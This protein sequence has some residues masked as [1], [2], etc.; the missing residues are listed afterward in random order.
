MEA[1]FWDH[2]RQG[3]WFL[4]PGTWTLCGDSGLASYLCLD[5]LPDVAGSKVLG[6][7]AFPLSASL[8]QRAMPPA[9]GRGL[10]G[11]PRSIWKG[12]RRNSLPSAIPESTTRHVTQ[13]LPLLGSS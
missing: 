7:L 6:Y 3:L 5:A 10:G 1:G 2:W 9:L 12:P 11:D 8:P 4:F 13:P